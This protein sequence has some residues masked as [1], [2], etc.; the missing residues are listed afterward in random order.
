[1]I[2]FPNIYKDVKNIIENDTL[3]MVNGNLQSSDD[4][5]KLIVS[6]IKEID[7]NS[8]KNLYIKM[9][10]VRY[11]KI[12]KDLMSNHG[13][14]PVIIYFSDKKKTVKLDKS[15]WIDQ[16]SDIINYLKLKLGKDNVKLI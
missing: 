4:E 13:S 12:R 16:N 10:Y 9:E 3:V 1:M 5:L 8:F 15:L 2:I 6:N 7:E 11:N 14:T